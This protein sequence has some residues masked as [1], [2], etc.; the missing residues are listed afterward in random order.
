LQGCWRF[1]TWSATVE[2]AFDAAS[3]QHLFCF[4]HPWIRKDKKKTIS[5]LS[6]F[7][8]VCFWVQSCFCQ[9]DWVFFRRYL[10][11]IVESMMPDLYHVI[12]VGHST[13]LNRIAQGK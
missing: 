11:F 9:Q 12:P 10:K 3:T 13:T 8:S 5:Y 1:Q 6:H 7:F 4:M 2:C